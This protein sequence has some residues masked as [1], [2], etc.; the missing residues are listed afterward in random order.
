MQDFLDTAERDYA[1]TPWPCAASLLAGTLALMTGWAEPA[2]SAR[3]DATRQR[4][5]MARKIVSNLFF[6]REHPDLPNG[7][8]MVATKLHARWSDIA[9]AHGADV[10]ASDSQPL[11]IALH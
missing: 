4:A 11:T 8:R 5:L 9:Q 3:L 1:G 2:P 10:R 7:L 6:L